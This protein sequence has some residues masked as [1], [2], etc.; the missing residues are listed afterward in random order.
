MWLK[1]GQNQLWQQ[2]ASFGNS[3]H[4]SAATSRYG[5]LLATSGNMGATFLSHGNFSPGLRFKAGNREPISAAKAFP[6]HKI[7]VGEL[8][9][10][11]T[12][13][14]VFAP[15]VSDKESFRFQVGKG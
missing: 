14:A 10:G 15:V 8:K 6:S 9:T 4:Q 11:D 12:G 7:K 5:S 2:L 1:N 3:G 13:M